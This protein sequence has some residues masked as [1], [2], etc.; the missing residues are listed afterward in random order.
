MPAR[1][2]LFHRACDQ[3]TPKKHSEVVGFNGPRMLPMPLA[4]LEGIAPG[5]PC[6]A[7]ST[8]SGGQTSRQLPLV[9]NCSA[10][11]LI[12]SGNRWTARASWEAKIRA[13]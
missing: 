1:R 5:A 11:S 10:V 3:G 12:A 8:G 13:R 4:E 6:H 2:Y 9:M 7:Q